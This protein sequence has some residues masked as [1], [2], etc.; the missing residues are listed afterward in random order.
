ME[1][2]REAIVQHQL[3]D[4]IDYF[5]QQRQKPVPRVA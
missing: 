1:D 5:Y 4:F 2:L 3:T